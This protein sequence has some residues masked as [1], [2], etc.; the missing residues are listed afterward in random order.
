LSGGDTYDDIIDAT[1]TSYWIPFI[2]APIAQP[3]RQNTP[4]KEKN[5]TKPQSFYL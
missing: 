4:T 5:E 2:T 3:F 1:I